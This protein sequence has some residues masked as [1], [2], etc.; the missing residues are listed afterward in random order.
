MFFFRQYSKLN[1]VN[2][3]WR[4]P[5][6]GNIMV[7]RFN[8]YDAFISYRHTE[9]DTKIMN[10]IQKLTENYRS[11]C[12]GT[13]LKKG[14]RIKR[15]FTDRS[16]LPMTAD[17]GNDITLAL[18]K[19]RFLIVIASEEYLQSRW[20]MQELRTFL[21]FNQYSIDRVLFVHAGGDPCCIT[22]ILRAV[23]MKVDTSSFHEPF[24]I[25]AGAPTVQDSVKIIKKE[26]LRL[27]AALIGCGYD[28]LSQRHKRAKIR[29]ILISSGIIL[30]IGI[31]VGSVIVFQNL[32][33]KQEQNYRNMEASISNVYGLLREK[34]C[35]DAL[36]QI[37]ALYDEY[38]QNKTYAAYLAEQLESAAIQASYI[39]ALSAFSS[40][41]LPFELNG[42]SVSSD[43]NHVMI[44][45]IDS[46]RDA[47]EMNIFLYDKLLNKLSEHMLPVGEWGEQLIFS[48]IFGQLRL[49]YLE[50][51]GTFVIEVP[52]A[53]QLVFS[54][55]GQLLQQELTA[56]ESGMVSCCEYFLEGD[57]LCLVT[58]SG[59]TKEIA[60]LERTSDLHSFDSVS[61]T[62]DGRFVL[63]KETQGVYN[64]V[65]IVCDPEGKEEPV[66]IDLGNHTILDMQYQFNEKHQE[67]RF[68]FNLNI[69]GSAEDGLIALCRVASGELL[70][71]ELFECNYVDDFLLSAA[72]FLYITDDSEVKVIS[73][74]DLCLPELM[75]G[76]ESEAVIRPGKA[77]NDLISEQSITVGGMTI[78]ACRRTHQFSPAFYSGGDLGI[79]IHSNDGNELVRFFCFGIGSAYF[80]HQDMVFGIID[81]DEIEQSEVFRFYNFFELI[82]LLH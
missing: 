43:G 50:S 71:C 47:G 77:D 37:A 34:N 27:V 73:T 75:A 19:S 17:L 21:Q 38:G 81:Y 35:T 44:F 48:N 1:I 8:D 24:Y 60:V 2:I 15:L 28:A 30:F 10:T 74:R 56:D 5:K 69:A 25:S 72:D 62:P 59:E 79:S 52:A 33:R 9:R 26:Y 80:S 12:D 22:D 46:T 32:Q 6:W 29:R 4:N 11:P 53:L 57:R 78:T 40:E 14:E 3:N 67:A 36:T 76:A 42:I 66:R 55:D 13:Y 64:D 82:E 16:E 70:N 41:T 58:A 20:C 51:D 61:V 65:L 49:D 39:P 18:S 63:V 7:D 23:G 54:A 31:L 68:F 45:D